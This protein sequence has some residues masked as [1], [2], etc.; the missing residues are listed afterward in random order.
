MSDPSPI[1][2]FGSRLLDLDEPL[3]SPRYQEHRMQ[4]EH[5]LA[6]AESRTKLVG[7]VATAAIVIAAVTLPVI[8]SRV[9]GSPDWTDRDATPLSVVLGVV[10]FLAVSVGL[11]GAASY[12]SRW[13]P[14][15]RRSREDLLVDSVSQLRREVAD[16]R[17]LFESRNEP[18]T[19]RA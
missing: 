3:P 12:Y 6:L 18:P 14:L 17:R 19:D 4:L 8:G 9:V 2:S 1:T 16:L 7:R 5:R 15:V 13:V 10:Y 11:V